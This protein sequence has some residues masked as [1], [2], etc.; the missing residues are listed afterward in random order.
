MT[1]HLISREAIFSTIKDI[2][3]LDDGTS[4]FVPVIGRGGTG[5]TMLFNQIQE[6]FDSHADQYP[7]VLV[8][9]YDY[10]DLKSQSLAGTLYS[11]VCR[12][13]THDETLF[14]KEDVEQFFNLLLTAPADIDGMIGLTMTGLQSLIEKG[15]RL[16]LLEDTIEVINAPSEFISNTFLIGSFLPNCVAIVAG[17]PEDSTSGHLDVINTTLANNDWITHPALEL[18]AFT[19]EETKSYLNSHFDGTFPEARLEKIHLL[20][21][22]SPIHLAIVTE[23][24]KSNADLDILKLD[25]Q[26]LKRQLEVDRSEL[27]SRFEYDLLT[28][29]SSL[30]ASIDWTVLYLA[31]LNRRYDRQIV[32][33]LIGG[34]DQEVKALEDKFKSLLYLRKSSLPSRQSRE[35]LH[36]EIQRMIN[37]LVWERID[38]M[39]EHRRAITH[40]VIDAYYLPEM[41]RCKNLLAEL[42]T[43]QM[44]RDRLIRYLD[45]SFTLAEL[46]NEC[47]DYLLRIDVQRGKAYF[48]QLAEEVN[49]SKYPNFNRLLLHD[50]VKNLI[51]SRF[52]PADEIEK[53][54]YGQ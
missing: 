12:M 53:A 40:R 5:K 1:N 9:N 47:L 45:S 19:L 7:H 28:K 48:E 8:I 44:D 25:M 20:T 38:F 3:L 21:N 51:L 26:D 42:E 36:D 22:G 41:Q 37:S 6:Y 16:V 15:I 17:R 49:Q 31:Y 27:L 2:I 13:L 29:I 10:R 11:N 18:N 23:V 50:G 52:M 43:E 39:K 33:A 30:G 35:M 4:H 24:L 54:I 14:K 34:T 46:Q 32:K